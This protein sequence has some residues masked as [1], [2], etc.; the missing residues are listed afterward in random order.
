MQ[1]LANDI[2]LPEQNISMT[3]I[4]EERVSYTKISCT[5]KDLLSQVPTS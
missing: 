2:S 3:C 5:I 4:H 1:D